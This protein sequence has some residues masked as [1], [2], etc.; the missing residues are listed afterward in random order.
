L[1]LTRRSG[2]RL[3]GG[4]ATAALLGP[5]L[6][7]GS[8]RL[9]SAGDG[10]RPRRVALLQYRES[11]P[12]QLTRDAFVASLAARGFPE[13]PRLQLVRRDAGGSQRR[14][15]RLAAELVGARPDLLVALG[16]PSLMAAIAEAPSSLPIVFS[17]CSNPW[18]AGAGQSAHQHRHNVTGTVST[19]PVDQQLQLARTLLP[20]LTQVG[21]LYNPAEA[22]A[23]FEAELLAQA[24]GAQQVQLLREPVAQ[25]ADLPLA[26]ERLRRGQVQALMQVGDYTT[27]QGFARLAEL[28]WAARLPLFGVDPAFAGLRGCLAVVG[29]DPCRDGRQAG[30]LAARVLGGTPPAELPFERPGTPQ[31]WLNAVTAR[32]LGLSLPPALLAESTQ[33]T[34]A[35]TAAASCD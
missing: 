25:P 14:C 11:L 35:A 12:L 24:A 29:W 27:Q 22:N 21:L 5:V 3:L 13:G 6:A 34:A 32:H 17:Y 23:G 30:A 1:T 4:A 19:N 7:C 28:A 15:R 10:S 31:V 16:T 9:S 20:E 18:A 33:V 26:W 8:R 2:L